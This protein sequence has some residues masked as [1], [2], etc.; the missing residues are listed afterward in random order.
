MKYCFCSCY[1]GDLENFQ[2]GTFDK[3]EGV[4]YFL[5]TNLSK[6]EIKNTSWDVVEI[7]EHDNIKELRTNTHVSRYYKFQLHKLLD[8]SYDFVF[9]MDHYIYPL[10]NVDWRFIAEKVVYN[11]NEEKLAIIQKRHCE[12]TIKSECNFVVQLRKETLEN[13]NKALLF[14]KSLKP[15][16]NLNN[17]I[18]YV[19]NCIFGYCINH[20]NTVEFFDNFW[21]LY[22]NPSYY[23]YRDQPLWNFTYKYYKKKCQIEK[24]QNYISAKNLKQFNIRKYNNKCIL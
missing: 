4:D 3:V 17:E 20:K 14:M 9:Y 16:I 12:K 21:K 1:V 24:M 6:N 23:T 13:M 10:N 8:K 18:D 5:F 15:E 7:K 2:N 19:E 11:C 22:T